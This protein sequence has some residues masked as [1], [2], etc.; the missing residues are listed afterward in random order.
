[1]QL[2]D[3]IQF[4]GFVNVSC[5]VMLDHHNIVTIIEG[6]GIHFCV[7][8]D[9]QGLSGWPGSWAE[10]SLPGGQSPGGGA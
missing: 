7:S 9:V 8:L 4:G 6:Y 2:T 10:K 1:M 5:S 3:H